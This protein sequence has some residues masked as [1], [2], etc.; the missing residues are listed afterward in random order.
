MTRMA[1]HR[2]F[3]IA[4]TALVA[5]VAVASSTSAASQ[6]MK[7]A[8]FETAI[9]RLEAG[10]PQSPQALNAR[11]DYADFLV[12]ATAG[13]C[14]QR[15]AQAQAQLDVVAA[16]AALDILL[17]A[18]T[19][20][21]AG[22][23]YKIHLARASCAG[24]PPLKTELQQALTTA[25][26]A[27]T[28]YRDALDYPS[29]V[30]MQFNVAATY[31]EL[32][33]TSNAVSALQAA[34]AMDHDYGFR[35]D[36]EDNTKL[37]LT[38]QGKSATDSEV[39]ALMKDFPARIAD[40]NFHWA[41]TN[42]AVAITTTDSSLIHG[43]IIQSRAETELK[44]Q[45]RPVPNGWVLSNDPGDSHYTL[46]DWPADESKWSMLYFLT[47]ALLDIPSIQIGSAGDF[48]SVPNPQSFGAALANES[49]ARITALMGRGTPVDDLYTAFSG[50]FIQ[51]KAAE[52]YGIQTGTW[53]GAKLDQG[54]WYRMSTPL[55]LPGLGLGHYMVQH[56]I[57]FAFTRMLPCTAGSD[58]ICVEIVAHATPAADDLRP[59]IANVAQ[60]LKLLS[61][62]RMHHWSQTDLR[63]V[64]D[65]NTLLPY[66]TDIKQSWYDALR[67]DVPG[68]PVVES[69]RTVSASTYH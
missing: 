25:Q 48:S 45:I 50:D 7:A 52:N 14:Q 13:D 58:S 34:I 57:S 20:R 66:V 5:T 69:I 10:E 4:A 17:P 54:A 51:A 12:Q 40:L 63:L 55:N 19:A 1:F 49:S 62:A 11:L 60:Q 53:I 35:D 47:S 65:P 37:L 36:A 21:M 23:E 67:S 32:G 29:S 24:N 44:R 30:V 16:H 68:E 43:K 28:L 22:A 6:D 41:N 31:R 2:L 9:A 33:D 61:P 15:L 26:Q 8:D 56:N 42:A 27:V 46:G 59:V 39:G 64:L 18:G 38:W 3:S